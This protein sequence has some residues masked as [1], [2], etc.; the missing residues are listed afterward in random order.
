M[1]EQAQSGEQQRYLDARQSQIASEAAVL[2]QE[3]AFAA[4]TERLH[5]VDVKIEEFDRETRQKIESLRQDQHKSWETSKWNGGRSYQKSID[6]PL[7][8]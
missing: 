4:A 8:H 2:E 6:A 3:S 1:M 5:D 7:K